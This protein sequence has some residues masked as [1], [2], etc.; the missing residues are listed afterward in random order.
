MSETMMEE[1]LPRKLGGKIVKWIFIL[2]NIL[3][4]LWL[5]AGFNSASEGID[6][7]TTELEQGAH[8]VGTGIGAMLIVTVWVF[9][10]IILT[11]VL[12]LTRG[13]KVYRKIDDNNKSDT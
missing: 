13:K 9:G 5:I 7:Y 12:L 6:Q 10:V 2:F 11:P 4:V 8:A 3:M 1:R